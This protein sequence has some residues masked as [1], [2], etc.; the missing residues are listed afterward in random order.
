ME[1][2]IWRKMIKKSIFSSIV[3]ES[4]YLH[5]LCQFCAILETV[6]HTILGGQIFPNSGGCTNSSFYV[7][8]REFVCFNMEECRICMSAGSPLSYL[9]LSLDLPMQWYFGRR[10]TISSAN[11]KG[12]ACLISQR[13]LPPARTAIV[14]AA[15]SSDVFQAGSLQLQ[16]QDSVLRRI[17]MSNYITD[18]VGQSLGS[19]T[20]RNNRRMPLW[21]YFDECDFG[22]FGMRSL[23]NDAFAFLWWQQYEESGVPSNNP[24]CEMMTIA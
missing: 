11:N 14:I 23:S 10:N 7:V 2:L 17:P 9:H 4:G 12:R 22:K 20:L 13:S 19:V 1:F 16:F 15:S 6:W 18:P 5:Q 21:V 8:F 24:N 3:R